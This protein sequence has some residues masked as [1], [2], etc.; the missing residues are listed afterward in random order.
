MIGAKKLQ[1][2]INREATLSASSSRKICTYEYLKGREI[3]PSD[4]SQIIERA[5]FIHSP[6]EKAFKK[7]TK[8]I[9]GQEKNKL[10]LDKHKICRKNKNE[11]QLKTYVQKISK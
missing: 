8:T 7:E 9:E 6:F 1:H 11:N 2:N 5:K 10:K 3:L 4:Q